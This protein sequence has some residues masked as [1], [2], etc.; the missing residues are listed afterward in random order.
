MTTSI[1]K[2]EVSS[3][4]VEGFES[5]VITEASEPGVYKIR[6]TLASRFAFLVICVAIVTTALAYGTVHYWALGLFNLGAL[7][8]LILW[9]VDAW[10]L[11]TLRISR[12]IL[13][14]P[15]LGFI[16]LAIVQLLPFGPVD[17]TANIANVSRSLSFDPYSTRLFLIQFSTLFVY[18]AAT[19]VFIDTPHRLQVMVRTIVIFG[20]LL[21]IFGLTQ[22]IASPNKVYWVRELSQSTAFGPFINRHHFAGYMELT[23]ALPLGLLFAGAIDREKILLYVFIAG[24]MGVAL[25]MTGSRG[26]IIS[27]VLEILF[28]VIVTGLIRPVGSDHHH[29]RHQRSR[30]KSAGI[31]VVLGFALIAGLFAGVMLL[32]GESSIMRFIDT[33]NTDDPS[34]GRTHFWAVTLEIIKHNPILGTGLGAFGVV[35]TRFDSRN[36]LFR[37]EQAHNDYLQILSDAGTVG[38]L[39]GLIFLVLLF[40]R[41]FQRAHS[42]DPFRRG[43]A[44]A[45]AGGCFAVLIHS[46]FDFTLHTTSNALLFL[47]LAALATLNGRVESV[48]RKRKR[49]RRSSSHEGE[50]VLI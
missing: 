13:Q 8:I 44:L 21:A 6:H 11:R 5:P 42:E 35:Y 24:L 16:L 22:S 15:L 17:S 12:S 20:F 3:D 32:G 36:G 1:S 45:A 9:I 38:A 47:I 18:F 2:K 43:I 27:L 10:K 46:F 14:L 28:F 29:H 31:R 49:K 40:R 4:L 25:V 41:A 33:V 37:L 23:I 34:T 39:I 19:L 50:G 26:G 30:L 48:T 7:T